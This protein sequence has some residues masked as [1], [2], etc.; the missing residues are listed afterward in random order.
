MPYF[1][2][3]ILKSAGLPFKTS[4]N[5]TE[6]AKILDCHRTTVMQIAERSGLTITPHQ[7]IYSE[8]FVQFFRPEPTKRNNR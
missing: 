1:K 7:R 4:Y 2:D 8:D 5:I 6:S 3:V